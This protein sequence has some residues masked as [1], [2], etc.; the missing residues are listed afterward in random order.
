MLLLLSVGVE[1]H[2]HVAVLVQNPSKDAAS[3]KEFGKDDARHVVLLC[4]VIGTRGFSLPQSI[5]HFFLPD[6]DHTAT[7][8]TTHL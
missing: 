2:T 7:H 8:A 3:I 1:P 4:F 6:L 5:G